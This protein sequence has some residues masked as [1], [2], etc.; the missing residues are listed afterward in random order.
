MMKW[1]F[2]TMNRDTSNS[3]MNTHSIFFDIY[4]ISVDRDK[5]GESAP[6]VI[7][8]CVTNCCQV[9]NDQSFS[10]FCGSGLDRHSKDRSSL[11]HV[12]LAGLEHQNLCLYSSRE[13]LTRLPN[14]H[15][16]LG[17]AQVGQMSGAL[18]WAVGRI[19]SSPWC[20]LHL[21]STCVPPSGFFKR[22][23]SSSG[24]PEAQKQ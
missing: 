13:Y 7:H 24:L 17:L 20:P 5:M 11:L 4:G 18:L 16:A 2:K 23:Y 3:E 6:L 1:C 10:Y 22:P 9:N 12:V 15:G 14:W 19:P 21:A 8:C